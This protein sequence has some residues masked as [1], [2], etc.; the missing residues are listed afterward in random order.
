MMG[1]YPSVKFDPG[2]GNTPEVSSITN[3]C[4]DIPYHT[5]MT[6]VDTDISS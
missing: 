1:L 5:C 4:S 3:K 6:L 2:V